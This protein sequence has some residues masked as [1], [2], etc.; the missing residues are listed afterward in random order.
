VKPLSH[1][2]PTTPGVFEPQQRASASAAACT[3]KVPRAC[4][5][6]QRRFSTGR[7]LGCCLVHSGS[8]SVP[9]AIWMHR[10]RGPW[11]PECSHPPRLLQCRLD[12]SSA[13]HR[14]LP[15]QRRQGGQSEVRTWTARSAAL[16]ASEVSG[17]GARRDHPAHP[18]EMTHGLSQ[19]RR[20]DK[21]SEHSRTVVS[22]N[23]S[24]SLRFSFEA[25]R[26][27]RSG[28]GTLLWSTVGAAVAAGVGL[29]R[30]C[31]HVSCYVATRLAYCNDAAFL[32]QPTAVLT[33]D[34]TM[35][36]D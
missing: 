23:E 10:P 6:Q 28:T 21:H 15:H 8:R 27:W 9:A 34:C 31:W 3:R 14:R 13:Y 11:Q 32:L 25:A 35:R 5:R 20:S 24:I 30:V 17:S 26:A 16:A 22:S 18:D 29:H 2:L 1:S 4:L 19:V 33:S 12:V 7:R 36:Q